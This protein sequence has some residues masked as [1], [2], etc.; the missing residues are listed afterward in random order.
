MDFDYRSRSY[1]SSRTFGETF[2]RV[3]F[4]LAVMFAV[5]KLVQSFMIFKH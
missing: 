1:Q 2:A 3:L 5:A 4:V